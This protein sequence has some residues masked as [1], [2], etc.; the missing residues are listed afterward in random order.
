[1][2]LLESAPFNIGKKKLYEGVVGKLVAYSCKI[3]YQQGFDGYVAF[4][5][6]TKLTKHYEE[7]LGAV[8]YIHSPF[9]SFKYN[10]KPFLLQPLR[11][12]MESDD[13]LGRDA[14]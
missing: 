1:M 14:I 5:S 4:T 10:Q 13:D 7:T 12:N 8:T 3:S 11:T 2:N 9:F 6:K